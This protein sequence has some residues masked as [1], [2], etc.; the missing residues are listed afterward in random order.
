MFIFKT[1]AGI[2]LALS[3]DPRA[4][5]IPVRNSEQAANLVKILLE[6]AKI[7]DRCLVLRKALNDGFT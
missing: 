5:R 6:L 3:F 1:L 7:L 2:A 4:R